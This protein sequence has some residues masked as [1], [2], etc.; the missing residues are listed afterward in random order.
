MKSYLRSL[1]FKIIIYLLLLLSFI[2]AFSQDLEQGFFESD[3]DFTYRIVNEIKENYPNYFDVR[4]KSLRTFYRADPP[5]FITDIEGFNVAL[6]FPHIKVEGDYNDIPLTL[7]MELINATG[8]IIY[9]GSK[10]FSLKDIIRESE[11]FDLADLSSS[12]DVYN[13]GGS[14][15]ELYGMIFIKLKFLGKE[16]V[17]NGKLAD[18]LFYNEL[19]SVFDYVGTKIYEYRNGMYFYSRAFV[20][21][22]K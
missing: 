14:T 15:D 6:Q 22:R 9:R 4:V 17:T 7:S 12:I 19:T 18:L 3:E 21:N 5:H 20:N 10:N 8:K 11:T 1:I 2:P 13:Y 16:S